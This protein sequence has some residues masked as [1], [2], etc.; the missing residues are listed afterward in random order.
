MCVRSFIVNGPWCIEKFLT[1][2]TVDTFLVCL[3]SSQEEQKFATMNEI[4]RGILLFYF[5][6]HIPIT[7]VLDLQGAFGQYY[8]E[9]L[10]NL[11]KWY[12]TTY[13]DPLMASRPPWFQAFLTYAILDL[14]LHE[15]ILIPCLQCSCEAAVQLP[16]FFVASYALLKSKI[17]C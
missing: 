15:C 4:W 2:L 17:D 11:F 6:S 7:I 3:D 1:Q 9:I 5:I 8:P 14:G 12:I 13:N 16:F 10:Q